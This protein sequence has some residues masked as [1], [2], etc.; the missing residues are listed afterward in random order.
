V[1]MGIEEKVYTN[2]YNSARK[3][4]NEDF[5]IPMYTKIVNSI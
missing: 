1:L 5:V 4:F 3:Q 2:N